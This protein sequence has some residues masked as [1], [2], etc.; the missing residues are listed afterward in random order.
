MELANLQRQENSVNKHG[1]F[2]RSRHYD[3][4]AG[5]HRPRRPTRPRFPAALS[6]RARLVQRDRVCQTRVLQ[7]QRRT[8]G[9]CQAPSLSESAAWRR[10]FGR[11]AGGDQ[12][13]GGPSRFVARSRRHG[14]QPDDGRQRCACRKCHPRRSSGMVVLVE[15]AAQTRMSADVETGDLVLTGD[16]RWQRSLRSG[17]GDALVGRWLL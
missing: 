3:T 2:H 11:D 1:G 8:G 13:G 6:R 10:A 12:D 5:R 9:H 7:S 14:A 15:N 17:V 4:A 16:R